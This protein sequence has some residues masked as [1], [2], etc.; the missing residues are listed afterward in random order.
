M[1]IP[2]VNRCYVFARRNYRGVLTDALTARAAKRYFTNSGEYFDAL[3]REAPGTL[4]IRTADGLNITIRRNIWDARILQEIFLSR[5]YL[6]D[7]RLRNQP[8]I[9]DIGGYIGDFSLYAAKY[10][11][12]CRVVVYEPS[13]K[14]FAMLMRN[15]ESNGYRD[16]IEASNMAVSDSHE[17][18]MDID[19]PDGR[20]ANVSAYRSDH[21]T[22]ER[23]PSVTLA[24][25]I[26][27][28][29]LD[30]VDL[31][32]MDCEGGEYPILLS[33]PLEVFERIENIVFEYHDIDGFEC[34]LDAAKDRLR[35][36][37]FAVKEHAFARMVTAIRP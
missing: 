11:R 5:P 36:A 31:L 21:A 13:R 22:A 27:H 3:H 37:G 14:N 15:V 32:K 12:A 34:K 16:V 4:D 24:D 35:S 29:R 17:V 6:K 20:Q 8:T 9:V 25:L 26:E 18:L 28:H 10:L 1:R 2:V 30:I 19:V 7:L 33:T 23:T